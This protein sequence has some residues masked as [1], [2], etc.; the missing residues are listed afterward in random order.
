MSPGKTHKSVKLNLNLGIANHYFGG[1]ILL[2]ESHATRQNKVQ[3]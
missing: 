2:T 1:K 3:L